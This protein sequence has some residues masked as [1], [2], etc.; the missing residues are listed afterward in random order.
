MSDLEKTILD[1]KNQLK[2]G[3]ENGLKIKANHR[4]HNLIITG[5]GGSIVSAYLLKQLISEI[6]PNIQK[7]VFIIED[8]ENNSLVQFNNKDS[9]LWR[10]MLGLFPR[11]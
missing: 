6:F 1:Y 8:F 11:G 4:Y 5:M 9:L 7:K 10:P 2:L 3:V